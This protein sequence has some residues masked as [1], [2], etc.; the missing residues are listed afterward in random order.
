V[1]RAVVY[2][3]E[4]G[5]HIKIGFTTNL[6]QRLKAFLTSSADV[7]LLVAIP[8]DRTLERAIHDKLTECRITRELFRRE[9]R[10]LNFISRF[11]QYG[12]EQ[13]LQFLDETDPAARAR[14]KAEDHTRRV[15]ATRQSRAEKDAYF[16]SLVA[17]RKN[18]LGW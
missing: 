17:E 2:F 14:R 5:K 6:K 1:T 3:V 7:E 13:A 11:E 9:W 4:I 18:R 8:G 10:V 16:A 12:L 15:A